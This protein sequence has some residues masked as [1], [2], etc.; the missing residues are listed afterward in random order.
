MELPSLP[1]SI[2]WRVTAY[3]SDGIAAARHPE[4]LG[5]LACGNDRIGERFSIV[6]RTAWLELSSIL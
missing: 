4:D 3:A 6:G 2:L 1:G 5:A